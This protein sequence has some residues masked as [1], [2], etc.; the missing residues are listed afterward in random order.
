M[1]IIGLCDMLLH[2]SDYD[3]LREAALLDNYNDWMQAVREFR[4]CRSM[5]VALR[6]TET[7]A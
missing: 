5:R 3:F 1:V 2:A 6:E 7:L 4:L